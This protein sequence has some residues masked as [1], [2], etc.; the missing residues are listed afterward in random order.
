MMHQPD[1]RHLSADELDAVHAGARSDRIASHLATCAVC[2]EIVELDQ[3]L[4]GILTTLPT[5]EPTPGFADRV[6]AQVAVGRDVAIAARARTP[7]EVA[8]RR[9]IA[10]VAVFAG[11][12][13]VGGFVW[14][15]AHPAAAL[16]WSAPALRDTGHSLW[17]WLQ[18]VVT[19]ISEQS[20]FGG[21]RDA[22]ATPA[23]AL[24]VLIVTAG[25]YGVALTGFRRLL[26]EPPTNAR[27]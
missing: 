19:N 9:R 17:L 21:V 5:W 6:M 10:A 20:W 3:R 7:R 16:S 1:T 26:S 8:A 25:V 4:L 27:S 22:L 24:P 14:A 11:S 2:V 18:T 13:V 12:A 23:R 15:G